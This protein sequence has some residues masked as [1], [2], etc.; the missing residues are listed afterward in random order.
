VS[1]DAVLEGLAVDVLEDDVG[2]AAVLARVDY[3]NNVRMRD[4][5][6]RPRLATEALNLVRLVGDLAVQDLRG[7]PPLER[8]VARQVDGG[9]PAATKLRLEPVA[10]REHGPG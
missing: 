6:N 5:R 7:H 3:G 4:L 8:L 2:A 10:A 1:V 9:H